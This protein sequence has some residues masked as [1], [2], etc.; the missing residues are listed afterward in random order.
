LS[1]SEVLIRE[2]PWDSAAFGLSTFELLDVSEEALELACQ[3]GHYT[4]KVDPLIS[5]ELLQQYGFYYCDTLIEPYCRR[6]RFISFDNQ[7]AVISQ[8]TSIDA[9][10]DICH[11][12]FS[13]GRFHRD[14]NLAGGLADLRYDN[15]IKQLHG[16]GQVYGL[17][18]GGELAGFIGFS[19]NKLVL[20]AVSETFKGK[21]LAKYLWSAAC[22]QLFNLG[23]EELVSSVS[24]ANLAVVNL[25]VSLG[26]RFRNAID[27]YHKMVR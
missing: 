9:I 22:N 20:H 6:E 25:Y 15:W 13:H 7:E 12:I 23:H 14:F 5:T 27:V 21:G 3:P 24:A 17:F 16:E 1:T 11:G 26:F 18:Y 2:T 8:D 4:A 10:V 19:G